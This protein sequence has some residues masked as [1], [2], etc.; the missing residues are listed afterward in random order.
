M[1]TACFARVFQR[2]PG[3]LYIGLR[4]IF[5]TIRAIGKTRNQLIPFYCWHVRLVI[6]TGK[7]AQVH[8]ARVSRGPH[9]GIARCCKIRGQHAVVERW[10]SIGMVARCGAMVLRLCRLLRHTRALNDCR[11][12]TRLRPLATRATR[13]LT[14]ESPLPWP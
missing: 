9:V 4:F 6:I 5:Q 12:A 10:T 14:K 1:S 2:C 13:A 11:D 8:P 3:R 7:E